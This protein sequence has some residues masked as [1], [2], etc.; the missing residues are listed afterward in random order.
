MKNVIFVFIMLF[1]SMLTGCEGKTSR[2]KSPSQIAQNQAVI[3]LN[4]FKTGDTDELKSL[5]CDQ[6]KSTHDLDKE[7]EE[8]INFI[9]GDIVNDGT[10]IGMSEGG[11]S[12]D[13]GITTKLDIH[14]SIINMETSNGNKYSIFFDT[15]LVYSENPQNIGM[16][17]IILSDS[18]NEEIMIGEIIY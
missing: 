1:I 16:T 3:I 13:D 10:W 18:N 15:Y 5:F 7:L 12:I 9:K 8:A 11:K 17:Y 4:C 6:V 2:E 14:P